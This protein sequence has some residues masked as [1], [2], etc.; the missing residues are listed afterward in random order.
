MRKFRNAL[1]AYTHTYIYIHTQE[2]NSQRNENKTNDHPK[3]ISVNI[4]ILTLPDTFLWVG[5]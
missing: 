1:Y 2:N 3:I 5:T 4:L